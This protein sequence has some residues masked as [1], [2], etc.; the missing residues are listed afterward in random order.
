V[1]PGDLLEEHPLYLLGIVQPDD[2]P[3]LLSGL[4]TE[5]AKENGHGSGIDLFGSL[6]IETTNWCPDLVPETVVKQA[7][8]DWM[9]WAE[10]VEGSAWLNLEETLALYELEPDP[11]KRSFVAV[12]GLPYVSSEQALGRWLTD[13]DEESV[14]FPDHSKQAILDWYFQSH[15]RTA[16]HS[17]R[18]RKFESLIPPV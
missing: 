12:Q 7:Y 9:E 1:Q 2:D 16:R 13:R 14:A 8:W 11:M 4:F 3:L 18:P 10:R 15:Y 5:I 6:P 17:H